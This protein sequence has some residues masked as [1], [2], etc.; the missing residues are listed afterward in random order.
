MNM[1]TIDLLK[2][3]GIPIKSRPIGVVIASVAAAVPILIA[4]VMLGYYLSNR[5]DISIRRQGIA[6]YKTKLSGLSSAVE[7]HKT[8]ESKKTLYNSSLSEVMS[9]LSRHTQW[10]PVLTT[11][12][13]NMPD[14]V[15][16]P[17]L[18]VKGRSVKRKVPKKDDPKKMITI[19]VPTR[20]LQISVCGS[21]GSDCGKAV[22]DLRDSVSTFLGTKLEQ[23]RVSQKPEKLDGQD[24][25]SYQIDCVFKPGL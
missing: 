5:I 11:L 25:I 7:L 8:F 1:F 9:S 2:G 17:A 16:L 24:V 21:P 22:R 12:V 15:V 10:T 13:E 20:T 4:I 19:D 3:Q 18:N 14:S 23:V 6:N